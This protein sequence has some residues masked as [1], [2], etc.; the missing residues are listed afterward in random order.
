[1]EKLSGIYRI[2]CVKNGNYYYGSSDNL[3]ERWMGHKN[4]LKRNK[5]VNPRV[6]R[7]WNKYG[8]DTFRFEHIEFV[9]PTKL[10]EIEDTY[11]KEHVG[12][13]HCMNILDKAT[14][15]PSRK[16]QKMSEDAKNRISETMKQKFKNGY[17]HPMLGISQPKTHRDNISQGHCKHNNWPIVISPDG[18]E[19]KVSSL[20]SFCKTHGLTYSVFNRL[21]HN[22]VRQHKGWHLKGTNLTLSQNDYKAQLTHPGVYPSVISPTGEVYN[23][24]INLKGFCCIHQLH[25]GHLRDV[26]VGKCQVHKGWIKSV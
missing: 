4:I 12:K 3:C 18:K 24:I 16:D 10:L 22:K 26:M 1:M 5:H 20:N 19:C 6:Q 9:E 15:P 11:L 8:E 23:N 13:P 2:V 17:A 7:T 21:I 25:S 14:M